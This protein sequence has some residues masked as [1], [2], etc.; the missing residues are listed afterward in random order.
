MRYPLRFGFWFFFLFLFL[1][2]GFVLVMDGLL[3]ACLFFLLPFLHT[4][5][6]SPHELNDPF[7][8]GEEMERWICIFRGN[9]FLADVYLAAVVGVSLEGS[10]KEEVWDR[11]RMEGEGNE[12]ERG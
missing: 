6:H 12:R 1:G 10:V 7:S 4:V 5:I 2:G 8:F 9:R 3:V 11:L